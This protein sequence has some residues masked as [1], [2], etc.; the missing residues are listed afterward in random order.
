MS[1]RIYRAFTTI[2][3]VILSMDPAVLTTFICVVTGY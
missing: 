2:H 1:T 3:G